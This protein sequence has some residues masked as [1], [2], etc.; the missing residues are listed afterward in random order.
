MICLTL[1]LHPAE[2]Y[3][4]LDALRASREVTGF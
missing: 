2:E 3:V 1:Y 4:V